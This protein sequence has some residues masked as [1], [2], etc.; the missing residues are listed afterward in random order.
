MLYQL[1]IIGHKA[2]Q[3]IYNVYFHPLRKYPGPFLWRVSRWPWVLKLWSGDL[4]FHLAQLHE[5]YGDIV[6]IAP[7]ELSVIH[8][9]AWKDIYGH[10]VGINA[11]AEIPKHEG[12]YVLHKDMPRSITNAGRD[13]HT[14]L[15]RGLAHGFSERSMQNQEPIIRGYVDLLMSRLTENCQETE[16]D[17]TITAQPLN[18]TSWYNWTTFDIIGDLTMGSPFHCL[19]RVDYHP[20][21]KAVADAPREI[22]IPVALRTLNYNTLINILLKLGLKKRKEHL[23]YLT[24]HLG[25]RIGSGVGRPDLVNGLI[26]K[27]ISGV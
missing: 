4:P 26:E 8:E 22:A 25:M 19:E 16:S 9:T 27:R 18:L 24:E 20:W 12:F 23:R 2:S 10:R 5:K 17:D 15:R 3:A 11:G 1:I 14:M 7:D 13:Q 21:V 6:R